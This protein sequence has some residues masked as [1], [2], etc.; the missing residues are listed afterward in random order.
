M[1]RGA[2]SDD[3]MIQLKDVTET[4][5][6]QKSKDKILESGIRPPLDSLYDQNM[7]L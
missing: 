5:L 2:S 4:L 6:S 1:V 3:H 7:V